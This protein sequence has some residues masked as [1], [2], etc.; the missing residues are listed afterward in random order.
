MSFVRRIACATWAAP[1]L[2]LCAGCDGPPRDRAPTSADNPADRAAVRRELPLDRQ[3]PGGANRVPALE[4][5][6]G[7][8]RYRP[9]CLFLDV[10]GGD[11][12]G[13]VVPAEAK[14]DGRRLTGKLTTPDG[15]PVAREIGRTASFSGPV[16]DNPGAGRFSCDTGRMLIADLF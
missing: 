10:G 2:A 16:V 13:L 6:S 7:T 3:A 14:F 12:I 15:R 11:E 9:G 1:I 4:G 5:I 8:L